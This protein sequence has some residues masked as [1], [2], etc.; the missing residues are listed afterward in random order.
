MPETTRPEVSFREFAVLMALL[1]SIVAISIDAMLPALGYVADYFNLA[2]RNHAQYLIGGIFIG[3][4]AG[5]LVAGPLSDALGRKKVLYGGIV[6]YL[7]GSVLCY[8]AP[9]FEVLMAGRLIQGLGVAGPYVSTVSIVR[10]KYAGRDMA[11]VMSIV[12]MIFIMVPA[13]APALGQ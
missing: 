10:D 3:M 13:I 6:L 2:D 1:M 8:V 11:R 12:M 7:A 5:Q 4:G 9:T